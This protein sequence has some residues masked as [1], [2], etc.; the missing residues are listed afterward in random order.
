[1]GWQNLSSVQ[2]QKLQ[3]QDVESVSQNV[4]ARELL[5]SKNQVKFQPQISKKRQQKEKLKNKNHRKKIRKILVI[6]LS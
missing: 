6:L 3:S 4:A 5:P 1:M 2:E